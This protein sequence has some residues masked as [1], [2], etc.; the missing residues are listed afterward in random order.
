MAYV[1]HLDLGGDGATSLMFQG[2][3]GGDLPRCGRWRGI[4][5]E[6]DR[7]LTARSTMGNG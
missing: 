5:H 4:K 3:D 1:S 6:S 7:V 2:L